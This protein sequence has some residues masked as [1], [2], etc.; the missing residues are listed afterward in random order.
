MGI[1]YKVLGQLDTYLKDSKLDQRENICNKLGTLKKI[2][3][4]AINSEKIFRIYLLFVIDKKLI[5]R[6]CKGI[7]QISKKKINHQCRNG[8]RSC[9]FHARG[10]PKGQ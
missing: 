3:R 7:V 1:S 6:V 4:Q 10:K 5:S 9:R 2:K 8:Q